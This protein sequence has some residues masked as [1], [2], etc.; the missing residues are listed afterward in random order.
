MYMYASMSEA[1]AHK[2]RA[3]SP[4]QPH[5]HLVWAQ[6]PIIKPFPFRTALPRRAAGQY[7]R[8]GEFAEEGQAR[9]LVCRA[10][11]S[12]LRI[13]TLAPLFIARSIP[14]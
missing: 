8:C 7:I 1:I 4:I 12:L 6:G 10:N 14:W 3:F 9:Q 5:H 11:D 13:E 2:R